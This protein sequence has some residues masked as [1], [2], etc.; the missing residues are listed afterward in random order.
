[1]SEEDHRRLNGG[2]EGEALGGSVKMCPFRREA[3]FAVCQ[4]RR[5]T[6]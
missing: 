5:D 1:M 3:Y 6:R 2:V 4:T